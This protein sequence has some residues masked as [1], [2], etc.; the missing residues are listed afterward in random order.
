MRGDN[1]KPQHS[2]EQMLFILTVVEFFISLYWL[3]NGTIFRN[4]TFI[5]ENCKACFFSSIISVFVQNFHWLFF[6]CSLHNLKCFVDNPIKEQNFH[7]RMKWYIIISLVS[8]GLFTFFVFLTEIF[9]ISVKLILK[10]I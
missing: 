8:S 10:I 7:R 2:V 3:L 9:G 6:T 5:M 1:A 4:V